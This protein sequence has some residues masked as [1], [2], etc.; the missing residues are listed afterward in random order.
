MTENVAIAAPADIDQRRKEA[1]FTASQTQ[2]IYARF[3]KNR[4][5]MIALW[6]LA[7]MIL[8]GLFAP[9]LSPYDPNIAGRDKDYENG[10]PQIPRFWDA[11]GFSARPF[12]YA[13]ERT[14]SKATNFRWVTVINK[15]KRRYV[16]LFVQGWKYSLFK[17]HVDMPG[18]TFDADFNLAH[19]VRHGLTGGVLSH[20]L[21]RVSRALAGALEANATSA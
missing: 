6:A 4:T 14:R 1:Y 16:H 18:T 9:F 5:A 11:N 15:D 8:M 21:R 17:L 12:I 10:A 2:L 7:L 3:R 13:S 20:L 19:P